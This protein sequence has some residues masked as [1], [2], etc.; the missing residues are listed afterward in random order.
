MIDSGATRPRPALRGSALAIS[1]AL[2]LL[3]SPGAP[4]AAARRRPPPPVVATGQP[5]PS[6]MNSA[7]AVSCATAKDCWA[8]GVSDGA[9]AAIDVTFDGGAKWRAQVVPGTLTVLA[10]ISCF[11]TRHCM[12]V[13][14][15]ASAGAVIVTA[16]GG[17]SW[18]LASVPAG[19]AE[20]TAVDCT[21]KVRCIS[22]ETDGTNDWTSVTSNFGTAW[23]RGGNLPAGM[24]AGDLTC[25]SLTLCLA[26][27]YAPLGPGK[28][29]GVIATST[30]AGST[31][32][33]VSLPTGVGLLR[34]IA[35]A[36]TRCLAAGTSSTATTGYV[37]G[38]GQLLTSMDGGTTWAIAS[39][40][41]SGE[42][43]YGIACPSAQVCVVVGTS[44]VGKTQPVPRGGIVSTLDGGAQWRTAKL[45]YV[46]VGVFAVA[47]P[48]LNHCVAAG[49]NVLTRISL[50]LKPPPKKPRRAPRVR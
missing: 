45:R 11:D 40:W 35:C 20:V 1:L 41:T 25:P 36:G 39:G 34:S 15:T 13:G 12:A 5:A 18:N 50:P 24:T 4:A 6:S 17:R 16:D 31:W 2:V 32:S 46:P 14:T 23:V 47:C 30:T 29:G 38:A 33:S 21:S 3:A 22:L 9:D 43:A 8:V 27:G 28:G 26:A 44:W 19:A 49:G 42:D 7:T 37:P 48:V 10:G